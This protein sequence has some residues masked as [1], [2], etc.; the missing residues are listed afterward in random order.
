[1]L[2]MLWAIN[3]CFPWDTTTKLKT[4][5]SSRQLLSSRFG[6]SFVLITIVNIEMAILL[7]EA[8]GIEVWKEPKMHQSP[9]EFKLKEKIILVSYKSLR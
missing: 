6:I 8:F 3:I 4:V 2:I 5:T 9:T 1:M 7:E